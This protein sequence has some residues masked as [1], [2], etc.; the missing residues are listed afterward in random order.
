MLPLMISSYRLP[1]CVRNPDVFASIVITMRPAQRTCD[2][3]FSRSSIAFPVLIAVT[4]F[5]PR[6]TLSVLCGITAE[7]TV[8]PGMRTIECQILSDSVRFCQILSDSVRSIWN[9]IKWIQMTISSGRNLQNV[10]MPMPWPVKAWVLREVLLLLRCLSLSDKFRR[11]WSV[12][13]NHQNHTIQSF[14][15]HEWS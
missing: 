10:A 9:P 8:V 5:S 7:S 4:A 12:R 15:N 11:P 14:N 13:H 2:S 1:S 3:N 6:E